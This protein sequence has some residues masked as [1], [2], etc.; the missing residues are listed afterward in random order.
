MHSVCQIQREMKKGRLIALAALL[1]ASRIKAL[2]DQ[3]FG[4][5]EIRD[6]NRSILI[7]V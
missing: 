7:A 6:F 2:A 4:L 1:Q 3:F 5:E